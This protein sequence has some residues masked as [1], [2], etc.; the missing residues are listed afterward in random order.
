MPLA[1]RVSDPTSHGAPLASGPGSSNVRIGYMKAWRALPAGPVG[2]AVEAAAQA[3]KSLMSSPSLTPASAAASLAQIQAKLQQA[4]VAASAQTNPASGA[5]TS[6]ALGTLNATN[7]TLATAWTAASAVPGG[8]PAATTAYTEGLKAAMSAAAGAAM[9]SM[10]GASDIH[11]CPVPCPA[12]PHGPGMVTRGSKSVR[13]N[14][15]PAARQGDKVFEACGG[16]DPI[17]M[18]CATVKIG[19]AGGGGSGGAGS[20]GAASGAENGTSE[21]AGDETSPEASARQDALQAAAVLIRHQ[22]RVA[23]ATGRAL[24]EVCERSRAA[25]HA[26]VPELEGV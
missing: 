23:A 22:N 16:E 14:G 18:G 19:D 15:L 6:S 8:T 2:A 20:G 7:A 10:A 1:A 21:S 11:T 26:D 17:A 13:I 12:P 3:I 24:C 9:S 5:T 4:A 25:H